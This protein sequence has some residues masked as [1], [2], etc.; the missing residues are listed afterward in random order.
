[1]GSTTKSIQDKIGLLDNL[2]R[3]ILASFISEQHCVF[4]SD[5]LSSSELGE[6]LSER[7]IQTFD[8]QVAH[9][10]CSAHT[11]IDDFNESLLVG[12]SDAA[13]EK[14]ANQALNTSS[15]D[16]DASQYRSRSA[17]LDDIGRV[18]NGNKLDERRIADIVI[19]QNLDL[20]SAPVQLQAL[21]L[22]R[23]KRVFTRTAMHT[24]SKQML[25]VAVTS[26]PGAR[27]HHHLNDLFA[28]SHV[29]H[30]SGF[31]RMMSKSATI[32]INNAD[33]EALQNTYRHVHVSPEIL[34]YLHHIIVFMRMSRYI[35]GGVT[36]AATR[37]L[38]TTSR[39]LAVLDGVDFV[40]PNIVM[41]AAREVYTHRVILA[42]PKTERSVQWGSDAEA[43]EAILEGV[44]VEDA[45][46][47]VL[48]SIE[49]PL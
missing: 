27:L 23:T 4:Y 28:T 37:F 45:I 11:S 29:Q 12:R 8:V 20:A 7:C 24:A 2:T 19:A 42:T 41:Q 26:R 30:Q 49:P 35:A 25:F 13:H 44:T 46:E 3:T 48:A 18:G 40:A 14:Q 15:S 6:Y 1:M 43:V 10:E 36:P 21:E 9:V 33:L 31:D 17:R 34:S 22:I 39:A 38:K 16:D 32:T 47:D 5:E